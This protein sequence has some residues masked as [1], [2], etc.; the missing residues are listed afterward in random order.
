MF[1]QIFLISMER[2]LF[3]S[4]ELLALDGF[5]KRNGGLMKKSVGIALG[6]GGLTVIGLFIAAIAGFFIFRNLFPAVN[7]ADIPNAVGTFKL[8]K[9][10]P[11]KGSILGTKTNYVSEYETEE[12]GKKVAFTYML[13][14][15]SSESGA[16]DDFNEDKCTGPAPG[17]EGV[18]K[19]KNGKA[20]GDYRYCTGTLHYRH[21]NN[22][23]TVYKFTIGDA[24]K[25]GAETS[26]ES[27][28]AFVEKLPDNSDIDISSLANA[29][30]SVKSAGDT[31]IMTSSPTSPS[32]QDPP[33]AVRGEVISAFDLAKKHDASKASVSQYNGKEITIRGYMLTKP[34]VT[35]PKSGGLAS[36]GED[37]EKVA[38]EDV[39][40]S[41]LCWIDAADLRGFSTVKGG[42][43]VT[44]IGTF[45]GEYNAEL[46]PCR[47]VKAE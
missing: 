38:V 12:A 20:V 46:K 35:D 8:R 10:F 11:P 4:L 6:C 15:F 36:L 5:K 37:F 47:F 45:N 28:I 32:S 42:Q 23:A 2:K 30:P 21:K 43:Y 40:K 34:T 31:R 25:G 13:S 9:V 27:I 7:T 44:V 41:I 22:S 14:K 33:P 26:D 39:A 1:F 3:D 16:I 29:Y 17:K 24:T 18:L 19:D